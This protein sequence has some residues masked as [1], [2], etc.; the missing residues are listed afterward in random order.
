[1]KKSF[2]TLA[3]AWSGEKKEILPGD[4]EQTVE[5]ASVHPLSSSPRLNGLQ[6]AASAQQE[7][8]QTLKKYIFNFSAQLHKH[9]TT[10]DYSRS[11]KR[12]VIVKPLQSRDAVL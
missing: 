7:K 10:V 12:K 3:P 6:S 8:T 11:I 4:Q 5:R 1:M 9:F 2:T